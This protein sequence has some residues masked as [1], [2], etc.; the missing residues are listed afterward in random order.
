MSTPTFLGYVDKYP[1]QEFRAHIAG[2]HA[3]LC[4]RI[5]I[6]GTPVITRPVK[7]G[8]ICPDC[9]VL[10]VESTVTP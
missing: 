6:V 2:E 10:F 5:G 3:V 7:A 1:M 8:E 4:G 9:A